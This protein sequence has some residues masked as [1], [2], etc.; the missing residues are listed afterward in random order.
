MQKG[1]C[2]SSLSTAARLRWP[3]LCRCEEKAYICALSINREQRWWRLRGLRCAA[4]QRMASAN[5]PTLIHRNIV[6][7]QSESF[8]ISQ[9]QRRS[10]LR[11]YRLAGGLC[12]SRSHATSAVRNPCPLLYGKAQYFIITIMINVIACTQVPGRKGS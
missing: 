10:V 12:R 3:T 5:S 8:G 2:M 7:Q 9:N 6:F 4:W 1:L 11:A